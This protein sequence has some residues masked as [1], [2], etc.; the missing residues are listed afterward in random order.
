MDNLKDIVLSGHSGVAAHTIS[1][2]CDH[3]HKT[4]QAQVRQNPRKERVGG[5]EVLPPSQEAIGI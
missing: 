3:T 1:Q 2:W 4:V 5:D